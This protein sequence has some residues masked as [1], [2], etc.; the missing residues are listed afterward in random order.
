MLANHLGYHCHMQIDN[1]KLPV[2][3][4]MCQR[5][6][7]EIQLNTRHH[8][9]LHKC[10]RVTVQSVVLDYCITILM[11]NVGNENTKSDAVVWSLMHS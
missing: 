1:R 8:R 6:P 5:I 9:L 3:F 7:S 4:Q 2:I 10:L 11:P